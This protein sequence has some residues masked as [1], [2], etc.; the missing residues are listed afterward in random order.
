MLYNDPMFTTGYYCHQTKQVYATMGIA[1]NELG[2]N[3]S[4]I[5]RVVNGHQSHTKG[6]T[7]E[8]VIDYKAQKEWYDDMAS[9][10]NKIFE[11]KLREA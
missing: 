9:C 3:A 4:L 2:L 1:A 8:R 6:Y 10:L 5:G 7:F 11:I